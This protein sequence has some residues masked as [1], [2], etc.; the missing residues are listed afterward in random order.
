MLLLTTILANFVGATAQ[1]LDTLLWLY[2]WIVIGRALVSWL[3]PDP[4]NPIV[5]F[6]YNATEPL[7]YRVRRLLPLFA[8]GIDFSPFI[9]ILAI[10]FLQRFLVVTLYDLA[11]SL[12]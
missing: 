1:V 12:R 4:Y 10:V 7:M 11:R 6:L 5:R 2:M 3:S 9:V 8:G